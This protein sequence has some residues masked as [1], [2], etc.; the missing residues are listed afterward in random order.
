[1]NAQAN[2]EHSIRSVR[3]NVFGPATV[4]EAS[5]GKLAAEAAVESESTPPASRRRPIVERNWSIE[6]AF[7]RRFDR[8]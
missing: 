8:Q 6:I 7:P 1:M 5:V 2:P 4:V 3:A